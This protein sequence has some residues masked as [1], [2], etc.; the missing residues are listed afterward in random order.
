M[1]PNGPILAS[2]VTEIAKLLLYAYGVQSVR[3]FLLT[4]L[5]TRAGQSLFTTTR[6]SREGAIDAARKYGLVEADLQTPPTTK[7]TGG[8]GS[9]ERMI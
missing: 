4:W 1:N 7:W 9:L 2:V 3:V 5:Q 8:L 6:L